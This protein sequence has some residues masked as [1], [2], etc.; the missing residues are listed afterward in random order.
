MS[1]AQADGS[2][3]NRI[4]PTAVLGEGVELGGGNVIGPYTVI[5]GPV[6]IG[7]GNWI[8][9]H[10]TIGTP[11]EDRG[12]PH[13]VAWEDAPTGDPALDG[14]GVVIG[15][16]NRIRE[17]AGVH[18]GTWRASTLGDDCY[19]LRGSHIGHDAVVGDHVTLAC[20][21]LLGGHTHVWSHANLGMGTVVHQ[22]ARIG[23]GAMVGMG[24]AVRREV[25]A[26]TI[27]V[28]NPARASGVN[29]VGLSRRGLDEATVEA[30][31]PWVKG[32]GDLPDDGLP[33]D[34]STLVKAW[35]ARPR[36][37]H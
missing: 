37:E 33:D 18:Q 11:G 15:S 27:T 10:V 5:V 30:L 4:H 2:A 3:P 34:L 35:D 12:G 21:V 7:D 6:R 36:E 13:P 9:P 23:P 28:G 32:K 1:H 20:N 22:G 8:G 19:L 16:R 14:H 17:Y 29:L 31:T 26:F 25:G 24:S